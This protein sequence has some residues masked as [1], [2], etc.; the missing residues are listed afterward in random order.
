[1]P[2]AFLTRY[3]EDGGEACKVFSGQ[4]F[5]GQVELVVARHQSLQSLTAEAA[6]GQFSTECAETECCPFNM[7]HQ[8]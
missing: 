1:M 5:C 7:H 3:S 6:A 4:I 8:S 2:D